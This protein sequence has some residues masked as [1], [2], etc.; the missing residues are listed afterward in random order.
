MS[1][2]INYSGAFHILDFIEI[3]L[4]DRMYLNPEISS[5][6]AALLIP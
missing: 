5:L 2:L 4:V 6:N 1:I 3:T